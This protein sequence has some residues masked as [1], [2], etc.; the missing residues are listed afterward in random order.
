MINKSDMVDVACNAAKEC[1][2]IALDKNEINKADILKVIGNAT[3]D[4]AYRGFDKL[5]PIIIKDN[6]SPPESDQDTLLLPQ[7][8]IN[9]DF[10]Y[11]N[12]PTTNSD[13][14]KLESEKRPVVLPREP[15]IT[16][17]G[18]KRNKKLLL[19]AF[20]DGKKFELGNETRCNEQLALLKK[21][22]NNK[23]FIDKKTGFSELD[24]DYLWNEASTH[25]KFD[26]EFFRLDLLGNLVINLKSL[27]KKHNNYLAKKFKY[28]HE[29]IHSY[30]NGGQSQVFNGGLLNEGINRSKRAKEIYN[31][32]IIHWVK[33][34]RDYGITPEKLLRELETDLEHT[35][36]KYDLNFIKGSNGKWKVYPVRKDIIL[37]P[38]T[39]QKE[40]P[41]LEIPQKESPKQVPGDKSSLSKMID[42]VTEC[43]GKG[44]DKYF[45]NMSRSTFITIVIVSAAGVVLGTCLAYKKINDDLDKEIEKS[46]NVKLN[47]YS[48]AIE[49]YKKSIE[50]AF[51]EFEKT[52]T[53][54]ILQVISKNFINLNAAYNKLSIEIMFE[55]RMVN[56]IE[57]IKTAL[58]YKTSDYKRALDTLNKRFQ[59][60]TENIK[61]DNNLSAKDRIALTILID[62]TMH[63]N[64]V[65]DVTNNSS[66]ENLVNDNIKFRYAEKRK[67]TIL[68]VGSVVGALIVGAGIG[69]ACVVATPGSFGIVTGVATISMITE[70]VSKCK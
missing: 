10:N 19:R 61:H 36:K 2:I 26:A 29:H 46:V 45:S 31:F 27:P 34:C 64:E 37:P 11:Q 25:R 6:D 30:S 68:V 23:G 49:I 43:L 1:F 22:W 58:L 55:Y 20:K 7:N 63:S 32:S 66:V 70:V 44:F 40:S 50:N 33:Y 3:L 47:M 24:K 18:I 51:K 53:P 48:I 54:E 35:N 52:K 65:N 59:D 41:K 15:E 62:I 57:K 56:D 28:D 67:E 21:I 5:L 14:Q 42:T 38:V 17:T 12:Q 60:L 16:K 9:D 8:E 39:T 13:N 69:V 4:L